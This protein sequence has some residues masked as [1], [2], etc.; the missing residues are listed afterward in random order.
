MSVELIV[1]KWLTYLGKIESIK[2]CAVVVLSSKNSDETLL[3]S[4]ANCARSTLISICQAAV[5]VLV[6]IKTSKATDPE[7]FILVE[8]F[9]KRDT[10]FSRSS[11]DALQSDLFVSLTKESLVRVRTSF[12]AYLQSAH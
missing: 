10:V 6:I 8:C 5:I 1:I 3:L 12:Y 2:Y 7:N 11:T 9:S 4:K